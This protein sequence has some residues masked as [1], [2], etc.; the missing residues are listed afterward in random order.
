MAN[1]LSGKYAV[2]GFAMLVGIPENELARRKPEC[3]PEQ[4]DRM[5]PSPLCITARDLEAEAVR[6]AIEDA[7]LEA[8]DIGRHRRVKSLPLQV[9]LV[10]SNYPLDG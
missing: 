3:S 8:K 10:A 4:L 6:R 9:A 1:K 5:V 2:A 7:G